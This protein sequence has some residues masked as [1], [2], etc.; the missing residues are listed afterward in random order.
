MIIN[1]VLG[2]IGLGIVILVHETGHFLVARKAGIVV[3]A[4]SIGW[5]PKLLSWKRGTT[6]YRI[7]AF[8]IGGYCRMKGE[9]VLKEAWQKGEE[10]IPKEPGSF[11][12][13]KPWKRILVSVAGPAANLIFAVVVLSIIWLAGFEIQ[14]FGNKIIPISSFPINEG[15]T[16]P[17]PADRIG[18]QE[19][20]RII[21]LDGKEVQHYRDIQETVSVSAEKTI[22]ITI[23]RDGSLYATEITPEM[24]PETGI[25]RIGVYAWIDPVIGTVV[26]NSA[27]EKAGIEKGDRIIEV[28]GKKIDHTIDFSSAVEGNRG[29]IQLTVSRNGARKEIQVIPRINQEGYPEIGISFAR[30]S[31]RSPRIGP[32][33]AIGKGVAETASTMALTVKSIGLLFKGVNVRESLSGPIR[34]TYYVGEVATQ[35]FKLGIGS[36]FSNLFRFLCLLSVAIFFMNLLPIPALDGGMVILF[37]IEMLR[38]KS[39]RPKVIYRYQSI[40][41]TLIIAL[42]LFATFNDVFFLVKR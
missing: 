30:Q 42:F 38:G 12:D 36:G 10:R 33:R 15:R 6:E 16:E 7:S 14:T 21:E 41:I 19:G 26:E 32:F 40:G 27:A 17:Y 29:V 1:I 4:F 13:A 24:D 37:L 22:P 28:N 31:F 23:E 25:G 34:I 9:H 11:F 2:I 3:E 20:D 18:L 39:L 8:P 5:G 35:G